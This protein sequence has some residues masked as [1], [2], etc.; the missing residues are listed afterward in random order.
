MASSDEHTPETEVTVKEEKVYVQIDDK[1]IALASQARRP[2][3]PPVQG[4]KQ[5][6]VTQERALRRRLEMDS[7]NH[8]GPAELAMR[9]ASRANIAQAG[10][11]PLKTTTMK[12]ECEGKTTSYMTNV[13][14]GL[15]HPDLWGVVA[16]EVAKTT[17]KTVVQSFERSRRAARRG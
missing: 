11:Q 8:S 17:N 13:P 12:I 14:P 9:R 6:Y 4:A 10:L 1:V 15:S 2:I 7:S 5:E 16:R 3:T